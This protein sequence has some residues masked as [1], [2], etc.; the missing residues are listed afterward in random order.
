MSAIV[1][2]WFGSGFAELHPLLQLLH[3]KGGVLRGPVEVSFGQGLAGV[4]GRRLASRL[5]LALAAPNDPSVWR[6]SSESHPSHYSRLQ[7]NRGRSVSVLGRS[8]GSSTW[9][10]AGLLG[11]TGA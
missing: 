4:V 11:Q 1:E 3:R 8:Q 5:R 10:A 6:S 9:Q 7:G 2:E